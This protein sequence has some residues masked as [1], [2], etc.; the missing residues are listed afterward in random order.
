[1]SYVCRAL[2]I[3]HRLMLVIRLDPLSVVDALP[4]PK[5]GRC[6]WY[7][8]SIERNTRGIDVNLKRFGYFGDYND[9]KVEV[10][11]LNL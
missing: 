7:S 9:T 1:M 11:I 2:H 5:Y 8:M 6:E 3:A 10:V 4:R